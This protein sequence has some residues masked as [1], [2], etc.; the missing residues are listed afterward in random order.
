M[1]TQE[2]KMTTT[3]TPYLGKIRSQIQILAKKMV[4]RHIFTFLLASNS[5][6]CIVRKPSDKMTITPLF[7]YVEMRAVKCLRGKDKS[8]I[9][10]ILFLEL[11]DSS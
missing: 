7:G 8:S 11:D 1:Q 3:S 10:L 6:S 4:D 9:I 5:K 2:K